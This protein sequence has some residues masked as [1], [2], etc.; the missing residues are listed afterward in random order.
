MVTAW[1]T[2]PAV[3]GADLTRVEIWKMNRPRSVGHGMEGN[4]LGIV[5]TAK[6]RTLHNRS[7]HSRVLAVC[8][9]RSVRPSRYV[10]THTLFGNE[11]PDPEISNAI[12][13]MHLGAPGRPTRSGAHGADSELPSQRL[14]SARTVGVVDVSDH[15][16]ISGLSQSFV[17]QDSLTWTVD[18]VAEPLTA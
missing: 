9:S 14:V 8:P 5:P 1:L 10:H 4:P 3:K 18:K 2:P 17:K 16:A 13:S 15:L 7:A 11:S 6:G 12:L